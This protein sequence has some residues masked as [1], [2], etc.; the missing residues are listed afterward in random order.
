MDHRV[1]G[2]SCR[3]DRIALDPRI[4]STSTA[5]I[6][7]TDAISSSNGSAS[8]RS[9]SSVSRFA[10]SSSTC[11]MAWILAWPGLSLSPPSVLPLLILLALLPVVRAFRKVSSSWRISD[12][13]RSFTGPFIPGSTGSR[14]FVARKRLASPMLA[15]PSMASASS[16]TSGRFRNRP[17]LLVR[18]R[19]K[20]SMVCRDS[21]DDVSPLSL[22]G[23]SSDGLYCDRAVCANR[24][25]SRSR[26]QS[27]SFPSPLRVSNR[28]KRF[29]S[30]TGVRSS[31]SGC[32]SD[33]ST[34]G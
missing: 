27:I 12:M 4:S 10:S 18:N 25:R 16:C 7:V 32:S 23:S 34:Y 2:S 6:R 28:I 11:P 3:T 14:P 20:S 19:K 17:V 21:L 31:F 9:R 26:T 22:L 30:A 29:C 13:T 8:F 1:A 5:T 24:R 33:R 15:I